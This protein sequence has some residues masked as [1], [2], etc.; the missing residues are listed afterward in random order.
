MV[1]RPRLDRSAR[2]ARKVKPAF[3]RK[4]GI[5]VF[6]GELLDPGDDIVSRHREERLA[7]F[8]P[9]PR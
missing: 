5:L 9:R 7:L 4:H 2:G 3:I 1:T 6:S 8:L